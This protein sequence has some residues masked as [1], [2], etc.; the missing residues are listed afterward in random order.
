MPPLFPHSLT[1]HSVLTPFSAK[2][3]DNQGV[4]ACM[5]AQNEGTT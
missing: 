5:K 2:S 4:L 1:A 3:V